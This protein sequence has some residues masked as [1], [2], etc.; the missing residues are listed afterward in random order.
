MQTEKNEKFIRISAHIVLC[1]PL[2]TRFSI[3]EKCFC[4]CSTARIHTRFNIFIIS[5]RNAPRERVWFCKFVNLSVVNCAT[6]RAEFRNFQFLW[7]RSLGWNGRWILGNF[8]C[9]SRE[10]SESFKDDSDST[11]TWLVSSAV[12]GD[13]ARKIFDSLI[14]FSWTRENRSETSSKFQSEHSSSMI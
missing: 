11:A 12:S 3:Q 9:T 2:I 7:A 6:S 14:N 10:S 1:L 13:F 4:N 5:T 8:R